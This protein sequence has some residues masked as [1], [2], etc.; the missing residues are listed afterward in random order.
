[1]IGF[2]TV[3]IFGFCNEEQEY[4]LSDQKDEKRAKVE[5]ENTNNNQCEK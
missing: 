2:F 3:F 4:K 1:V 5:D